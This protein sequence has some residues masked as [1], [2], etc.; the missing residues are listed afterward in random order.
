MVLF[1]LGHPVQQKISKKT[2]LWTKLMPS[3][4]TPSD[5]DRATWIA[6]GPS[7]KLRADLWTH[8]RTVRRVRRRDL[9]SSSHPRRMIRRVDSQRLL[10]R[11]TAGE[12]AC[13]SRMVVRVGDDRGGVL[14]VKGRRQWRR[15]VKV[16]EVGQRP[17]VVGDG[18]GRTGV[19][20]I[21]CV[22]L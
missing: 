8:L 10:R 11:H 20:H 18:D 13:T 19:G 15:D 3:L 16:G 7:L 22:L 6:D 9:P 14:W 17:C 12:I 21:V 4:V 5:S 2:H 1:I